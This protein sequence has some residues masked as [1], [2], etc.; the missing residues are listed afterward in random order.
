MFQDIQFPT[1]IS[2]GSKG[3]PTFKTD[4]IEVDSGQEYRNPRWSTP[5]HVYDVSYGVK[6]RLSVAQLKAFY[7]SRQGPANSF[8]YKDWLDYTTAVD[9]ITQW[10]FLDQGL[11]LGDGSTTNFQLFKYYSIGTSFAFA[12]QITKPVNG[13][14]GVAV[15]GTQLTTGFT[16]NYT[17]GVLT[18]TTPPTSGAAITWGGQFD[19][20]ARF[21]NDDDLA[22]ISYDSFDEGNLNSI[23]VTEVKD[24]DPYPDNIYNG[25]SNAILLTGTYTMSATDNRVLYFWNLS[26]GMAIQLPARATVPTGGPLWFIFNNGPNSMLINDESSSLLMTLAASTMATAVLTVDGSNNKVWVLF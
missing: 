2:Y 16:V 19:V 1:D 20:H 14:F 23:Q 12:R 18:I 26:A 22:N 3:G 7:M 25:G 21:G 6:S 9:G 24:E 17:T 10:T 15:A 4:I 13:Q 8:R 11:G 5:R